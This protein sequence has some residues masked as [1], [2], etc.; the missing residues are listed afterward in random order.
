MAQIK[1]IA[2]Q[3]GEDLLRKLSELLGADLANEVVEQV[4]EQV[5]E[6]PAEPEIPVPEFGTIV[7]QDEDEYGYS[8]TFAVNDATDLEVNVIAMGV[9]VVGVAGIDG[10]L[11]KVL[12]PNGAFNDVVA[13]YDA[14][15]ET[16]FVALDKVLPGGTS[17]VIGGWEAPDTVEEDETDED[18]L[19]GGCDC[20]D[21]LCEEEDDN[22]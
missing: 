15:S 3:A 8:Y 9:E 14:E 10:G 22:Y 18:S 7:S 16:L 5:E 6:T 2:I 20:P 1:V 19:D 13:E 21:C 12:A 4:Q 17:V 11:R